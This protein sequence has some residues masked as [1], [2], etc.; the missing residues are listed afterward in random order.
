MLKKNLQTSKETKIKKYLFTKD[1]TIALR[2]CFG[3]LFRLFRSSGIS[4]GAEAAAAYDHPRRHRTFDEPTESHTSHDTVKTTTQR[5]HI[6]IYDY[7]ITY[8]AIKKFNLNY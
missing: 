1:S 5:I 6:Y 3:T 7:T 2:S 8:N 4:E